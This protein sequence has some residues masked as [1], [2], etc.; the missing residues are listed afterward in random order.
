MKKKVTVIS[1]VFALLAILVIGSSLAWF[2]DEDSVTNT[3]TIGEVKIKQNEKEHDANGNLQE[4]TQG[5]MLL[6]V[7]NTE[8]VTEDANYVEKLVSV[9]NAGR[10]DAYVRTFIAVP[11]ALKDILH[12]DVVADSE[13]GWTKDTH[14]W[15]NVTVGEGEAAVEYAIVS[16]TYNTALTEDAETPYV[17]KGVYLDASVDVKEN[18]SGERQFCTKNAD[19]TYTFYEFD[20][21]EEVKVLVATQGC[22][23]AGFENG[24]ANALD[25]AFGTAPDF[26]VVMP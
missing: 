2:K 12:L 4:F 20:I 18:P 13:T 3:F 10:N 14:T 1:L 15:P 19:D 26:T 24:A 25:T 7:V 23:T 6:P 16:F 22:Q 5:Q 21:T 8:D 17:L 11:A 9:E